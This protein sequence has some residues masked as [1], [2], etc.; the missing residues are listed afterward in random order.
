MSGA[1]VL[2]LGIPSEPPV[3]M[4]AQALA[5]L[6]APHLVLNQRRFA[7]TEAV[8][9]VDD[10]VVTGVLIVGGVELALEGFGGVYT[11]MMSFGELPELAAATADDPRLLHA[12]RLHRVLHEWSEAMPGRVVNPARSQGSNASKPYQAQRIAPYFAVP[13]TLVTND[14]R[15]A[16]SFRDEHE[17]IVYKSI[18]GAR[19]IVSE[20]TEQDAARLASLATCPVQFQRHVDGVDIRVHTLANG[21]A[22]ATEVKSDATD[23]RYATGCDG[24]E[25]TSCAIPDDVAQRCL[26]LALALDLGFAGID[27]RRTPAGDFVCFEVNPS[28]AFS[29]YE[30]STGQPIAAALAA[31]LAGVE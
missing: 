26:A 14:P 3:A 21:R 12:Q 11:R 16:L 27:L 6:G 24:A 31:Y 25:L 8:V 10:D 30:E 28:P 17:R 23:Y 5:Q 29:Y 13:E 20:L 15:A 19:S 9:G 4:T 22:F 1:P 7:E 2:L 18:S